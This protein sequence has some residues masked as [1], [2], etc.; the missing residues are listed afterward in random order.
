[1]N[2]EQIRSS[3]RYSVYLKGIKKKEEQNTGCKFAS[4]VNRSDNR[5]KVYPRT[6]T[7][8]NDKSK[9]LFISV[10]K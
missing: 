6:Y 3:T 5:E 10:K 7:Q 9:F 2:P 8:P 4:K 1:M